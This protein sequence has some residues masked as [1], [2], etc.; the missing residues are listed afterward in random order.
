MDGYITGC[1]Y[2]A[3]RAD[4]DEA[5]ADLTIDGVSCIDTARGSRWGMSRAGDES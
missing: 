3:I 2:T 5:V 1:E 4:P